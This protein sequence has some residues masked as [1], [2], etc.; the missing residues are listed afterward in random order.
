[1]KKVTLLAWIR[2]V[3]LLIMHRCNLEKVKKE[4]DRELNDKVSE[5]FLKTAY[6]GEECRN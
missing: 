4:T 3:R 1:M 5:T 2:T 6:N